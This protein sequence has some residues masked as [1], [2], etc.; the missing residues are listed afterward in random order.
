MPCARGTVVDREGPV[1]IVVM[2]LLP[3]PA[4]TT[5]SVWARARS[6]TGGEDEADIR[7]DQDAMAGRRSPQMNQKH[8]RVK[9]PRAVGSDG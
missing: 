1:D 6:G 8:S 3:R 4:G 2:V 5:H 9:P 7:G